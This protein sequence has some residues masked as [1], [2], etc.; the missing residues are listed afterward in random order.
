MTIPKEALLRF[1]NAEDTVQHTPELQDLQ[2]INSWNRQNVK[3]QGVTPQ[4]GSVQ[5]S[6]TLSPNPKLPC[7]V[8]ET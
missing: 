7:F 8:P 6:M 5:F 2:D 4:V 3:L 1:L